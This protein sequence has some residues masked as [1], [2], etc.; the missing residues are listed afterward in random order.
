MNRMVESKYTKVT[1][2]RVS[3]WVGIAFFTSPRKLSISLWRHVGVNTIADPATTYDKQRT[4]NK[5]S[6][7]DF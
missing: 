1:A 6:L 4:L 7:G 3:S 2:G 5:L